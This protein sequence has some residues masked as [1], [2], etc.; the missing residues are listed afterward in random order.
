MIETTFLEALEK[1]YAIRKT[2]S[3]IHELVQSNSKKEACINQN[4]KRNKDAIEFFWVCKS[5]IDKLHQKKCI[6]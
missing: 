6:I 2:V 5:I 4:H 3:G 1:W